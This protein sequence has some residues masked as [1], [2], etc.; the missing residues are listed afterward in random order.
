MHDCHTNTSGLYGHYCPSCSHMLLA[1][2]YHSDFYNILFCSH[3]HFI[4]IF[5]LRNGFFLFLLICHFYSL[6]TWLFLSPAISLF[7]S[8]SPP[9]CI[10]CLPLW[11]S[12]SALVSE[13][14][15]L[16][17]RCEYQACVSNLASF[18]PSL[19]ICLSCP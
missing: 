14:W 12:T 5:Q 2:A 6:I 8:S 18:P 15:A 19:P 17:P 1:S 7:L 13:G 4:F 16:P 3:V 10:H 9:P 11:E